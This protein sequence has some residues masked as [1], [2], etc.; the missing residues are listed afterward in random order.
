MSDMSQR[1]ALPPAPDHERHDP[2]LV[3]Q[4]VAGDELEPE[5]QAEAQHLVTVC[6]AC[7]ALAA[8]LRVV[9]TTVAHE[10]VPP[11]RHD[12]RLSPEQAEEL[13]GNVLTRL[14]RRLSLPSARAFQ[15]AAAGILSIG[16]VF[17][18]AGYIWPDGGTI[19]VQSAPN[20][21][22]WSPS[23]PASTPIE[24]AGDEG[25]AAPLVEPGADGPAA[26]VAPES[27]DRAAS[28][29]LAATE[30]DAEFFE[31]LPESQAGSLERSSQKSLAGGG[32]AAEEDVLA[33][34]AVAAPEAPAPEAVEESA[35]VDDGLGADAALDAVAEEPAAEP[36]MG[37]AVPAPEAEVP[38]PEGET[39]ATAADTQAAEAARLPSDEGGPE[40]LLIMLG[41]L[42]AATGGGLL[43]LGWLARRAR[44]PLAP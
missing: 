21:V 15:P 43:V 10:P 36:E 12:F 7:A 9:S 17:V 5:Q 25:L 38:V 19:T 18:A 1:H 23:A 4:F 37:V 13:S 31:T 8:D 26:S 16:L 39:D 11:R 29:E 34:D 30:P 24:D 6:G 27:N 35:L 14:L 2:M 42:L 40:D 33:A 28:D 20:Y 32:E 41:V 3:A 44:D 22:D